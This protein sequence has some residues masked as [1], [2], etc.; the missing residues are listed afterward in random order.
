MSVVTH[1]TDSASV[2]LAEEAMIVEHV[3]TPWAEKQKK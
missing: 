2:L 3:R 1:R